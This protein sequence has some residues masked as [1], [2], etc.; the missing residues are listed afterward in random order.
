MLTMWWV[1]WSLIN[2]NSY[3]IAL[4]NRV[5]SIPGIDAL[6]FGEYSHQRYKSDDTTRSTMHHDQ[7]SRETIRERADPLRGWNPPLQSWTGADH[8]NK[9]HF[10][11]VWSDPCIALCTLVL[12]SSVKSVVDEQRHLCQCYVGP[13]HCCIVQTFALLWIFQLCCVV[14]CSVQS[15]VDGQR[16]L[17]HCC[18][19]PCTVVF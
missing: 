15:V 18:V 1:G 9:S 12:W 6:N 5:Q 7:N 13:L 3:I 16:R 8:C 2:L 14:Q 4:Q 11:V 19:D 17:W 10:D